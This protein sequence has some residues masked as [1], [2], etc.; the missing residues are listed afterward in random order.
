MTPVKVVERDGKY[1]LQTMFGNPI[2]PRLWGSEPPNGLPPIN[3]AFDT[4]DKARDAAE[5]WNMYAA[6][7]RDRAGKNRKK[8]SR[9][10]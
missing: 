5:L 7:C 9:R 1:I 3:D 8:W 2:G 6:W 4:K 10:S